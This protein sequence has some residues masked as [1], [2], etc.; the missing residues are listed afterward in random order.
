[1]SQAVEFADQVKLEVRKDLSTIDVNFDTKTFIDKVHPLAWDHFYSRIYER[2]LVNANEVGVDKNNLMD[3]SHIGWETE[4]H[5][6]GYGIF[7]NC[8]ETNL[9]VEETYWTLSKRAMD[10]IDRKMSKYDKKITELV[11]GKVP[12]VLP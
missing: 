6:Y 4:I 11:G 7:D 10:S 2:T 12:W 9:N 5:L 8:K 1:M 3:I